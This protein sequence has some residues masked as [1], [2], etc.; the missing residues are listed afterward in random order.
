MMWQPL[1]SQ[2][3]HSPEPAGFGAPI[4]MLQMF[5]PRLTHACELAGENAN[6]MEVYIVRVR[7]G[8]GQERVVV[9][10]GWEDESA[11]R[12]EWFI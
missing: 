2:T 9:L 12:S 4:C 11:P 5:S 3:R 1:R 8:H 10:D 7:G 6:L